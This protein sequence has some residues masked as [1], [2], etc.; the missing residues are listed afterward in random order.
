[1]WAFSLF[2]FTCA[3]V[4]LF[5][6]FFVKSVYKMKVAYIRTVAAYL[7]R[8]LKQFM[9]IEYWFN[10][11]HRNVLIKKLVCTDDDFNNRNTGDVKLVLKWRNT[12]EA[13]LIEKGKNFS[14]KRASIHSRRA[15]LN[16][17]RLERGLGI[18]AE[19]RV[20]LCECVCACERACE[21]MYVCAHA[22]VHIQRARVCM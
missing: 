20:C 16:L 6:C 4:F 11:T 18:V 14:V 19:Q 21:C 8:K 3:C 10:Y 17:T 9:I 22:L 13:L 5:C 12:G 2:T 15:Y 7:V 1:M